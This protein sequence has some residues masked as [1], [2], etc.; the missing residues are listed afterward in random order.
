MIDGEYKL[1]KDRFLFDFFMDILLSLEHGLA[2]SK[3]SINIY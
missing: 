1:S 3:P 2:H